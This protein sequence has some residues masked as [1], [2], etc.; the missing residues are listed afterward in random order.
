M[1]LKGL[2]WLGELILVKMMVG[3]WVSGPDRESQNQAEPPEA[4]EAPEAGL[5][6]V[7]ED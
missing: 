5:G 6:K 2:S 3:R 1:G 7:I 4:P